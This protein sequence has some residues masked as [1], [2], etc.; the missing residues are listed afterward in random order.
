MRNRAKRRLTRTVEQ[1]VRELIERIYARHPVGCCW[2]V[3]LDDE[4]WDCLDFCCDEA[5]IAA[6][7]DS[8]EECVTEGACQELAA[9]CN[10]KRRELTV[11]GETLRKVTEAW[12]AERGRKADD[13]STTQ[14]V[15]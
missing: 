10:P 8:E 11:T 4:N 15:A 9:L 14:A 3:V 6:S 1:Q 2:H 7:R 12:K 5:R 13:G